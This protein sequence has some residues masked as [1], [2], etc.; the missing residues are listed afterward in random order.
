MGVSRRIQ[1]LALAIAELA[2]RS[3]GNNGGM[4]GGRRRKASGGGRIKGKS[5]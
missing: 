2:W 3:G 5:K 4:S 1:W